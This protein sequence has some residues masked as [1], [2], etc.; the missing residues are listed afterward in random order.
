MEG[1]SGLSELPL[2]RGCPLF[3]GGEAIKPRTEQNGTERNGAEPE[4]IDA[5]YGRG[6]WARGQ[7]LALM[8]QFVLVYGL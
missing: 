4:V 6:H 2:Y 1:Q 5:Q 3:R 7:K 8:K